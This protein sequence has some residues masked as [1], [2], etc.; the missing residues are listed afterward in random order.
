MYLAMSRLKVISSRE[1]EFERRGTVETYPY[2]KGRHASV[3]DQPMQLRRWSGWVDMCGPPFPQ[4]HLAQ[5]HGVTQKKAHV[6]L[7][8][9]KQYY[10]KGGCNGREGCTPVFTP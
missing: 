7:S 4:A 8:V 2:P 9:H 1:I 3:C 6:T 10:R 5:L